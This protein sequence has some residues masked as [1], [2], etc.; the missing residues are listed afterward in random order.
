MIKSIKDG[1]VTFMWDDG[2]TYCLTEEEY[3]TFIKKTWQ[4]Q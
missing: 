4:L 1:Y 3:E 2:E